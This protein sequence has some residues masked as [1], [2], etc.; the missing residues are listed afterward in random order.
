[1]GEKHSSPVRP[2]ATCFPATHYTAREHRVGQTD[3]LLADLGLRG[4]EEGGIR[5]ESYHLLMRL[6][7]WGLGSRRA[8]V[9]Y[10]PVLPSFL[11]D[12]CKIFRMNMI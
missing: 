5:W 7:H 12:T 4:R 1:M 11:L 3:L 9:F 2:Q 10:P 8:L 6:G